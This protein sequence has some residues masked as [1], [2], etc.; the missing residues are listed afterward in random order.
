[1]FASGKTFQPCLS[2]MG[3]ARG[4][5]QSGARERYFNW[6]APVLPTNLRLG[7]KGL[8]GTYALTY[9]EHVTTVKSFITLGLEERPQAA[10][11]ADSH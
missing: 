1:M 7:W 10:G 3:K 4:L 11:V 5:P 9:Y 6:E 8:P 2:F